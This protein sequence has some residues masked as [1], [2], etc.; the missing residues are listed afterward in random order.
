MRNV[1]TGRD[2]TRECVVAIERDRAED[3]VMMP[4]RLACGDD[5]RPFIDGLE[6]AAGHGG[7]VDALDQDVALCAQTD[8]GSNLQ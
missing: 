2:L 6:D 3:A 1:K 8:H 4:G 7:V 5:R